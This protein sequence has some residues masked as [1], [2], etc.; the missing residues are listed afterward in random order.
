MEGV[1]VKSIMCSNMLHFGLRVIFQIFNCF[2]DPL[3]M[4]AV[5]LRFF[6]GSSWHVVVVVGD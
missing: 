2:S 4:V 6:I 3:L 1:S 5:P